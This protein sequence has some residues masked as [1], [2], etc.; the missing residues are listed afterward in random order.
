M[1]ITAAG[2]SDR[3]TGRPGNEDHY[4]VGAF[5][6]QEAFTA[7]TLEAGSTM[8]QQYG[9]LAAVADGMGGY[10]GGALASRVALETLSASYYG[11]KRGGCT[12]TE[13]AGCLERYLAQ[14]QQVLVHVLEHS[15]EYAQAGTTIAGVAM[16]P[17]DLL[18]VFHAGDS[19]VLRAT[20]G[21][22]RP[23]TVDH[24]PFG[25]DLTSGQI[26]EEEVRGLPEVS[27]LTRSLG[28]GGDTRAE[29]TIENSW[30]PEISLLIGTDGWH[31]VAGGLT[32]QAV[33]E[34]VRRGGTVEEQLRALLAD[35]VAADG[36]D[37]ATLVMV[38]IELGARTSESAHADSEV[39]APRI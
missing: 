37:N 28:A 20:A 15:P 19:R 25:P 29:I 10:A 33:Q 32:R 2:L 17:P 1:R 31:G 16:M 5:V 27:Q 22:V 21:Y 6:E 3:G 7:L 12:A 9:L 26:S 34:I 39:R 4:C 24:T 11:E 23:L 13:L 38:R 30:A 8:F 14:A 18:A 35:A 36:R